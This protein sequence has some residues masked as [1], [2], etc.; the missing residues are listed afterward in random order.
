M[1]EVS[2]Q[3]KL[4]SYPIPIPKSKSIDFENYKIRICKNTT[5]DQDTNAYLRNGMLN[6]NS[7]F[8]ENCIQDITLNLF[9]PNK[10]SPPNSWNSRL[11][12]RILN[13]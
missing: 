11:R 9:D 1:N 13:M 2:V 4:K 8:H 7:A 10:C 12:A 5:N 3:N 6:Y